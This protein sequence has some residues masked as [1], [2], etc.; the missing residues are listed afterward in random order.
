ME[1]ETIRSMVSNI[2]TNRETDAMRD[3][4]AAIA[5]KL[6]DALDHKK[7]E[8]A[9]GLGESDNNASGVA[10]GR[11]PAGG[12]GLTDKLLSVAGAIKDIVTGEA[13]KKWATPAE[14]RPKEQP[15]AAPTLAPN[16]AGIKDMPPANDRMT[17]P[18]EQPPAAPSPTPHAAQVTGPVTG[19]KKPK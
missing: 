9:S 14:P 6:T 8:I 1:K 4:D 15:P 13:G 16:I 19:T 17:R 5:D 2:I 12:S 18:K 3:F 7:Q 10:S 11:G